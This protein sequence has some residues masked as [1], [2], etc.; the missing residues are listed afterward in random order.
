MLNEEQSN[1]VDEI[2]ELLTN[3]VAGDLTSQDEILALI[4]TIDGI[5][6]DKLNIH[7]DQEDI[8]DTFENWE[9]ATEFEAVNSLFP[10]YEKSDEQSPYNLSLT[11]AL[12]E[13]ENTYIIDAEVQYEW[14]AED[15][16]G[17][18]VVGVVA[19]IERIGGTGDI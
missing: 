9:E 18:A 14:E 11:Y 8:D 19:G 16:I 3:I 7:L 10:L 15:E 4:N 6:R 1:T 2:N 17:C 5:C 12:G 13:T